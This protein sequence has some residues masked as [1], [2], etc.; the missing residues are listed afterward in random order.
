MRK[1]KHDM[2]KVE[3][4]SEIAM[5]IIT[6][7]GLAK[8]NYLMA[9]EDAKKGNVE[10]AQ[11]K[12]QEGSDVFAEAHHVHASALSDEMKELEPQ[13]TLLLVHAEDQLMN[14]ETIKILVQELMEIY[15]AK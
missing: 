5:K 2:S 12:L 7:A 9:L 3:R 1:G 15:Q 14:A 6:C 11:K 10:E 4:L 8:S 13:V